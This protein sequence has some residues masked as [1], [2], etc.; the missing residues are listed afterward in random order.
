MVASISASVIAWGTVAG[1]LPLGST[2]M[3]SGSGTAEGPT[4]RAPGG[5]LSAWEARPVC[6]SCTKMCP[7]AAWT[8]SVTARQPA[9]WASE[10]MPGIRA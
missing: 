3:G 5:R 9:T 2:Q 6:M 7:P 1:A 10:N 8:A 4:T